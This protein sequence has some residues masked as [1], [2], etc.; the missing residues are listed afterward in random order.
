MGKWNQDKTSIVNGKA[1]VILQAAVRGNFHRAWT[2]SSER[3]RT[4]KSWNQEKTSIALVARHVD[5]V[6]KGRLQGQ[7]ECG[8]PGHGPGTG[9]RHCDPGTAPERGY[10]TGPGREHHGIRTRPQSHHQ[11][12]L[13]LVQEVH[14]EQLV[15][16]KLPEVQEGQEE[17]WSGR[18]GHG[19]GT[20][21]HSLP[22]RICI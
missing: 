10:R 7:E 9:Q 21:R 4:R 19:P 14:E 16:Q 17:C 12:L 3:S 15:V 1:C 11:L 22:P 20:G 6:Y 5:S 8:G 13:H 2:K 18:P